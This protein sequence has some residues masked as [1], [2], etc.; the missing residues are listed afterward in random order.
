LPNL[1]ARLLMVVVSALV[2]ALAFQ[3]HTEM[4]ARPMPMPN[5]LFRMPPLVGVEQQRTMAAARQV[6]GLNGGSPA[7]QDHMPAYYQ[8]MLANLL[9]AAPRYRYAE[10]IASS[11]STP[12]A[13]RASDETL[14]DFNRPYPRR[15]LRTNGF[16]IGDYATGPGSGIPAIHLAEPFRRNGVISG[17][18]MARQQIERLEPPPGRIVPLLDRT[19]TLPVRRPAAPAMIGFGRPPASRSSPDSDAIRVFGGITGPAT[20]RWMIGAFSPAGAGSRSFSAGVARGDQAAF[21]EP[22]AAGRF[23]ILPILA[24]AA[25]AVL[26]TAIVGTRLT[27]RPVRNLLD[28]AERWRGGDLTARSGLARN[29]GDFGRLA[30][31]LESMADTLQ[32]RER[33]LFAALESTTDSVV[34]VDREWTIRYLNQR[35]QTLSGGNPVGVKLWAAYPDLTGTAFEQGC[36]KAMAANQPVRVEAY[37]PPLAGY[38]EVNAFPSA[39]G[40][41]LFLRDL[42]EERRVAAELRASENRLQLAREAAGFGVWDRDF[43]SGTL[44][45]SEEQWRL[46]GLKPGPGGPDM[47]TW[48]SCLHPEDRARIVAVRLATSSEPATPFQAEY[49]VVW[50]DGSVHW[51]QTKS[52]VTEGVTG[53]LTRAVGVTMDVT[54]AHETETGL[55]RVSLDLEARVREEVAAREAAQARA[56]MA[57]RMQALGQLAGGIAHD[58]NNVLQAVAGAIALIQRRPNDQDAIR[59]FAGLAME[60]VERG[61]SVTGRLL[62]FG[63]QGALRAETVDVGALFNGLREILTFTL[64]AGVAVRVTLADT[65]LDVVADKGQLETVLVNLA[66]NA[67][68][69]MP[70]GGTL[71]FAAERDVVAPDQAGHPAGLAP[72]A[73]VRI[74]V[75]DTG[76]GMDAAVLARSREPFFS[77]KQTGSGAGLGLP[78]AHGFAEQSGGALAIDSQPGEGTTVTLWLPEAA[79]PADPPGPNRPRA[80]AAH[81]ARVLLVDDEPIIREVMA[82]HLEEA[83]HIV[84]VAGG[85]VEALALLATEPPVAAL[86]SDLSMPVMNGLAVIRAAQD[87]YAGLPAIL[88]TGYAEDAAALSLTSSVSGP[89]S[90]LRKPV[91]DVQLLDRLET[92]LAAGPV[93]TG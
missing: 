59:R 30:A 72:S 39:D 43:A 46:H 76:T 62:S 74:T 7:S 55:R 91:T 58:I 26:L 45:W 69:A 73:Y 48:S 47:D 84:L 13:A 81:T 57:E 12:R 64:G 24:G 17:V 44:I 83:G 93:L 82:R 87:R 16:V 42:T 89:V 1:L 36:R 37:Y 53:A 9:A 88:L 61:A 66:T 33:A 70:S 41:T 34:A 31:A 79:A 86:I 29:R 20:A 27:R 52:K 25:L 22:G 65:R 49:R 6:L 80:R 54:A 2:P 38:F 32:A 8:R 21:A 77:T 60:A 15:A 63:R 23:G 51:L 90:L 11:G 75:A 14:N 10:V 18:V 71:T 67:R 68:D 19:G 50:P 4:Q 85:G 5:E 40:L 3:A 78:M 35:A 28:L 92:M 56:A